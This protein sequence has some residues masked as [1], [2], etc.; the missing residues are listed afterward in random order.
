MKIIIQDNRIAAVATDDYVSTG[1]EQDV[2]DA[3]DA[4]DIGRISQYIY[5]DGQL[6][7][8]AEER[9]DSPAT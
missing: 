8:A 5:L 3:P 7:D 6:S 9:T 1:M 2:I 4:F